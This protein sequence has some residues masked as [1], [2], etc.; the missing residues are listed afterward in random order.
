MTTPPHDPNYAR[1]DQRVTGIEASISSIGQN[2]AALGEKF[3]NRSRPQWMLIVG[4]LGLIVT[5]LGLV[6]AGWK[7][8]LDGTIQRQEYDLRQLQQGDVPRVEHEYHWQS[9]EAADT[10]AARRLERLEG[11]VFAPK[12]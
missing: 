6:L 4:S 11:A 2:I 7:A 12:P 9:G 1:L 3:D 10:E 5:I 8:P